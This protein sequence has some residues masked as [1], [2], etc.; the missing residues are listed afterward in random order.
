M[1]EH[2]R[3]Y[4]LTFR[5]NIIPFTIFPHLPLTALIIALV[6]IPQ[7]QATTSVQKAIRSTVLI[8]TYEPGTDTAQSKGS[9]VFV[10][11]D[12]W[13]LTNK[14]VV[15]GFSGMFQ[16]VKIIPTGTNEE[17]NMGCSFKVDTGQDCGERMPLGQKLL[18]NGLGDD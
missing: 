3:Q 6:A 1:S 18:V 14:H 17:A 4:F 7:A 15:D 9:G 10:N 12:G 13:I 16:D 11:E 5:N 8:E 2:T